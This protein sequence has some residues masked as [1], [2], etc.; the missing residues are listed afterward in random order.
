MTTLSA[1]RPA[2]NRL[3]KKGK[4]PGNN[5]LRAA[6]LSLSDD[7]AAILLVALVGVRNGDFSARLPVSW[8]GIHGRIADTFNDI[9]E[10]QARLAKELE[11][12]SYAVGQEGRISQ[13]VKLPRAVGAWAE[14]V[15]L[16]NGLIGALVWPTSEMARVVGSVAR[17]DLTQTVAL[18]VE[19][20]PL[21]GEFLRTAR[22]VNTMV[23]QLTSF[24]SEVT[25]V[26]REVGT[27]EIG[28]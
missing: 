15:D 6:T 24:T 14:E 1:H 28:R 17:G 11:R 3:T 26:A 5:G 20:R 22:I 8:T 7:E 21:A 4:R 16:V 27:E 13:R 23:H 25:R 10:M 19:G 12:V 18:E 9:V 2:T